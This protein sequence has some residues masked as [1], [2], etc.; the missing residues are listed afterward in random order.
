M[1]SFPLKFPAACLLIIVFFPACNL[2]AQEPANLREKAR[3]AFEDSFKDA[4]GKKPDERQTTIAMD[5]FEN[6]VKSIA[7][8]LGVVAGK[9]A[10]QRDALDAAIAQKDALTF[11]KILAIPNSV[12]A[13]ETRLQKSD[14]KLFLQPSGLQAKVDGQSLVDDITIAEKFDDQVEVVFPAGS[15]D[16]DDRWLMNV[17]ADANQAFPTEITFV[18][19]GKTRTRIRMNDIRLGDND[20]AMLGFRDLTIDCEND[21]LFD[22][23]SGSLTLGFS[24]V[25]VV[26]FDGGHAGC[27]VFSV[28]EGLFVH[29]VES[30][31]VGGLGVNP[32]Y[33][34]IFRN[35]RGLV[36]HFEK[37]SFRGIDRGLLEFQNQPN[38]R[39][40]FDECV[41]EQSYQNSDVATFSKCK[42]NAVP[43]H[44]RDRFDVAIEGRDGMGYMR[45]LNQTRRRPIQKTN[46]DVIDV[47]AFTQLKPA[48]NQIDGSKLID[49]IDEFARSLEG[50]TEVAFP[51]GFFEIDDRKLSRALREAG[52]IFPDGVRFLGAGKEKTKLKFSNA[53][54]GDY[55][56]DRLT[57][58]AMTIDC[59][60]DGMFDKRRGKLTL[61]LSDVRVMR[62]DAGHAG[63][64]IF[65]VNDG[66]IV[67][68]VDTDFTGGA[69]NTPGNGMVFYSS[70][71]LIGHFVNCSFAGI[72]HDLFRNFAFA[73]T[74]L[75]MEDCRFS[76][77]YPPSPQVEFSNC[78]FDVK[79][80]Q[81]SDN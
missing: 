76:R 27:S 9:N 78:D 74:K 24:N 15:F 61:N 48:T 65:T 72:N 8:D 70:D 50:N 60:N 11:V 44:L 41:L 14:V 59:G 79:P 28:N 71:V 22:K 26:R 75:W 20:V 16:I 47:K 69:G 39:L 67:R 55:D 56:V 66:L 17:F 32:G 35:C 7:A 3:Q 77:T 37:C 6:R 36:G 49:D 13:G 45:L 34:S 43:R 38:M 62:F 64:R 5:E 31:F 80:D 10:S 21:G 57:F 81:S 63:C 40:W 73:R 1:K 2:F 30:D 58:E 4:Y 54:L 23:R 46:L 19:S 25:K 12:R 53:A 51:V 33:G 18:G 68:A 29:A 52:K 42:F